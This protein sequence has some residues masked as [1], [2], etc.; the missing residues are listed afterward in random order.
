MAAFVVALPCAKR[1]V[2]ITRTSPLTTFRTR[3]SVQPRRRSRFIVAA[4]GG[5]QKKSEN[6]A[7]GKQTRPTLFSAI[8]GLCTVCSAI[9]MLVPMSLVH[10][11]VLLLDRRRRAL[12]ERLALTWLRLSFYLAGVRV[13]VE[14]KRHLE[15][16]K[17][18]AAL[19]V[20]NYQSPLDIFGLAF[21]QREMRFV[22]P[23]AAAR[24]PVVGWIM[25]FAQWVRLGGSDR[26]SQM[27]A[28]KNV[29]S[30][31]GDG[32]SVCMFPETAKHPS[33]KLSKFSPAAFRA[34][35]Q[36]G[37]PVVPVTI[38]GMGEM[39]ETS[40]VIP[41]RRP[42]NNVRIVVHAPISHEKDGSDAALARTAFD[43]VNSGLPVELQAHG[44]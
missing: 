41:V 4:D 6:D 42:T 40:G 3:A 17:D 23:A 9:A 37:V 33:G 14:G 44:L 22:V 5:Q 31:L 25:R 24:S 21:I 15:S 13:R 39:F 19:F 27:K 34:A 26:R 10:P 28:L 16:V 36:A 18:S 2:R 30:V 35:S 1:C 11:I 43:A 20:S 12:Q 7:S 8:L 29:T 38:I 32:S